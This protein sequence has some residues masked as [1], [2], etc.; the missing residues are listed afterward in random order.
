MLDLFDLKQHVTGPTHIMG[1]TIDVVISP[2][3]DSYISDVKTRSYDISHHFLIDFNVS[4][5]VSLNSKKVI[6]Y[7]AWK[8]IDSA[9]FSEDLKKA[10]SA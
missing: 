4:V 2:N 1:H 3:R 10:F 5:K 7:R 9:A 6:T 8:N